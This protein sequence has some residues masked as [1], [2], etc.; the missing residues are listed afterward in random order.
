MKE[1]CLLESSLSVR[2]KASVLNFSWQKNGPALELFLWRDRESTQPTKV[3]HLVEHFPAAV[4]WELLGLCFKPLYQWPSGTPRQPSGF[5]TLPRR[6]KVPFTLRSKTI[7]EYRSITPELAIRE[8]LLATGDQSL[9]TE[10]DL[11][12]SLLCVGSVVPSSA[13]LLC[14]PWWLQPQDVVGPLPKIGEWCV[15]F[16]GLLL[17]LDDLP[18]H[19]LMCTYRKWHSYLVRGFCCHNLEYVFSLKENNLTDIIFRNS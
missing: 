10:A 5:Q 1:K 14:F 9:I 11:P 19:D 8:R 13:W 7:R 18:A 12:L 6:I 2:K 15:A 3:T 16:L 17:G 4:Q